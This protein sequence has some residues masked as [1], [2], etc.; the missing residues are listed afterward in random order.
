MLRSTVR[1][2]RPQVFGVLIS[3]CAASSWTLSAQ[4]QD[5]FSAD[6]QWMTGDWGGLRAEWL[7]KGIDVQMGYTGES[8]SNLRGGY[9]K[10]HTTRYADQFTVGAAIDLHKLMGWNDTQFM[11][12]LTN[13]NGDNL[14]TD[15]LNDPRAGSFSATQEVQGTGS[16]SRLSELWLSKGWF[17][18]ALNI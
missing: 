12:Q 9:D 5:A 10:H 16:V 11:V 13:R 2:V 15:N 3:L 18:T 6:S 1:H 8:A 14:N 4:A 17:D 7:E